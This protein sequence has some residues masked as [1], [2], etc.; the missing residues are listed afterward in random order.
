VYAPGPAG[1]GLD[2]PDSEPATITDFKGFAGLAYISGTCVRTDRKTGMSTQL[3]F[4]GAD[5]RFMQGVYRGVD[6]RVHQGT[7]GLI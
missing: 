1:V 3:P 5:M 4:V 7:F 2:P 6:D